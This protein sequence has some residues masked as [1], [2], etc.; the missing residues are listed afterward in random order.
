M[1]N[2]R[3]SEIK[4][5]SS[6][7][8]VATFTE[9]LDI[10]INTSNVEITTLIPNVPIPKVLKVKVVQQQLL[11]TTDPLTPYVPY[12][13]NF[14]SSDLTLFKSKNGTALLLTDGVTNKPTILGPEDPSDPTRNFLLTYL[15][16][17]VYNLESG[18]LVRDIINSQANNISQA[19]Y[20]IKQAQND[21][22]LSFTVTDEVK[23]RG[24]G[25]FDRLNQEGAYKIVRVGLHPTGSLMNG[26]LSFDDITNKIVNLL[27]VS[28]TSEKLI[29]GTGNSNFNGLTLNLSSGTV[30]KLKKLEIFYGDGTYFNYDI[31]QYGYQINNSKYDSDFASTLLTLNNHQIKLS[32]SV[33]NDDAFKI[34][35]AITTMTV[36]YEYIKLGRIVD[37]ESVEL[38]TTRQAVRELVPPL[39]N[40]FTLQHS[41]LIV[42]NLIDQIAS[43]SGVVFLDPN[44]NP[45][46]SAIHPAF[47]TEIPF[48]FDALPAHAG[49]Y[50]IDYDTGRVF[51]YGSN[52]ND[53][54]GNFP[55]TATYFYRFIFNPKLDYTY[56]SDTSE[57]VASPLRLQDLQNIPCKLV[58]NYEDTL[59]PD[60]DFIPQAHT[61]V[62]DERIGNKLNSSTCL[63]TQYSPITNVFRIY[64]ETSGELYKIQRWNSH[65]IYF[66]SNTPP[67]IKSALRERGSFINITNELLLVTDEF[68]NVLGTRILV[69]Y[70]KYNR[71]IASSEDAIGSS[72]NNSVSFSRSDLFATELYYD[73]Q[74]S[75]ADLNTNRL[76]PTQYQIDYQ[77]GI[78]YVGVSSSSAQSYE[79]GTINYKGPIIV[80]NN[81]HLISISN[82][83]Q[84]INNILGVNKH[85]DYSSFEDGEILPLTFN[86]TDERF[87][88]KDT[89]LP[90]IVSSQTIT[91]TDD[92]KDVRYIFDHYDLINNIVPTNFGDN[93]TI[94]ANVISLSE[95]GVIKQETLIIQ[96]G[97][98]LNTT[99]ISP[100]IELSSIV[101]L[102]R[103]EDQ[104]QLNGT[105]SGNSIILE[106]AESP[107]VGESVIVTYY[108][109]LN[110]SATPIVD[111]NR[112]DYFIDYTYL[113]DEILVSYEYG[114]NCIDFRSS[115]AINEGQT[116]YVTYK[117]GALRDALLKNFGS[118]VNLPILNNSFDI[119]FPRENYREALQAA[120]QSFTKGPTIPAMKSLVSQI[121]HIEPEL[122]ESAF[123]NWSLGISHLSP[124]PIELTGSP[125]LIA[126]KYDN[127]LLISNSDETVTFPVAS[128]LRLEEGTLE[129]WVIP[130]WDGLDNDA[131][132]T[133]SLTKDGY[134]LDVSQIYIGSDSHHPTYDISHQFCLNKIDDLSP[135]GVPSAIYTQ[136]GIF[137]FYDDTAKRWKVLAKDSVNGIASVYSGT[138]TSSGE[139][140]D[141]KFI[142]GLG[143]INDILRSSTKTI[144]FT[145]NLDTYDIESPDGYV[146]GYAE[147]GY[148]PADGY[149]AGYSFDG[150]DFMADDEHYLFDFGQT[151]VTNRFSIFKDGRGYLNFKVLDRGQGS[152]K[153]Q[154]QVSTDISN[155]KAG[156]K[157][158]VAVSWKLNTSDHR[159]E[160]HL[161][162]DGLEVPNIIK[163]GGRPIASSSDRFRTV[164]PEVV[165][166]S[167]LKI[168]ITYNDL[169]TTIDSNLVYSDTLNFEALGVV[170]GD[171]LSIKEIGFGDYTIIDISGSYLTLDSSMFSSLNQ[172]RF[173]I[174]EFSAIVSSEID[175]FSNI[176]VSI[177][178][179]AEETEIPGLRSEIPGYEISKNALNQNVLTLLGYAEAGDQI[180][181]R[182]LGLNHR[183][184]REK[185]FIWGNTQN[186]LKTQLPSPINL[187]EVKITA[188]LLPATVI[189]PNNSTIVD[190]AF[191]ATGLITSLP[192]NTME[193]RTLNIRINGNNV[194]FSMPVSVTITGTTASGDLSEVLNFSAP[195][196]INTSNK[197]KTISSVDVTVYPILDTKNS[198]SL[199]IKEAY[200]LTYS[201]GNNIFPVIRFSYKTQT[202]FH[203]QGNIGSD[204]IVDPLGYF[205]AS[206]I[207]QKLVITSP[208]SVI[209]TYT[210]IGRMNDTTI[211][212]S[213]AL[214]TTFTDGTYDIF[215]TTI[216]RS[217]FQNGFFTLE[218]AGFV[219]TPFTLN[220]SWYEFDYS[221]YLTI[222]WDPLTNISA[223]I[224]SDFTGNK[225]A[226]AVI[227]ELRILS[228]QLT[229]VR[230]GETLPSGQESITTDFISLKPLRPNSDT[231][232]LLHFDILPVINSA[233]FWVSATHD[234]LQA[235]DSVNANFGKSLIVM[236][237]PLVVDNKGYLSTTSEGTIEFWVSPRYD[238][239]N[240][241][242]FRF[243][244]DASSAIIEETVSLSS[245]NV[246][247]SSRA[248]QILSVRLQTDQNNLGTD[249]F[250][251]GVL[252]NDFQTLKLGTALPY[253]Q[254]PVKVQYLPS[255][256]SGNRLSIYKDR[257]GYVIFNIKLQ[258]TD[259]Q[260]RQSIFW[261]RDSWHRIRA[262]FKVNR[263]D[264]LDELR[265]FV[266]GEERGTILFGQGL[267]FGPDIIF[268]Q[269]FAGSNNSA[270]IQDINFKDPINQFYIG[271]DYL[272]ANLAQARIDNLKI[273][274]RVLQP[275]TVAGQPI[276][277]NF[278]SNLD[279]VFPV[280]QDA[281]TTYLLNFDTLI[282]TTDDLTVVRDEKFGIFNFTLNIIDS[283]GIVSN[284]AKVQQI[285]ET[286]ILAL[287]PAQSRVTLNYVK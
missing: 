157:H 14:K 135:I 240:D 9:E 190:G 79:L 128:N 26:S 65:S 206:I 36:D 16:D 131:T 102:I 100:G 226:K 253:Q 61:E 208:F 251:G 241:P 63:S 224:G 75:T 273:S 235:G 22:Y 90:Y 130:E 80:P 78:V 73:G 194:N 148:F 272:K 287:K 242:N 139:V 125:Q 179:N 223:Y 115:Q 6:T 10:F 146:D 91:V 196:S 147:D 211:Q 83:Y 202:G 274:N 199:E 141:V 152:R 161:F 59:V 89:S 214:E 53:G 86:L 262:T 245:G 20:D 117:V 219:N 265:L 145:F 271:S 170:A 218:Q 34:P 279:V 39:V 221:T 222:P 285:L 150:I 156:Q 256:L 81:P 24:E 1:P 250:A 60:L 263:T 99:F 106:A 252:E 169:N 140:Y 33:L 56:D 47:T 51:V 2:I 72:F 84:S 234:F 5:I 254:T 48:K 74:S 88:N 126:G 142:P 109:K 23:T 28:V 92:I 166:G 95:I 267:L 248:A 275:L 220:Q 133:F 7:S 43:N 64:N 159:D 204:I 11:I 264:H 189:G 118:L 266:D 50:S 15:K 200:S 187:D 143:E 114:D 134:T 246:K 19:L 227:D 233:N 178:H 37:P 4:V 247:L 195:T 207:G 68:T 155:W 69:I 40:Q 193:G 107:N 49:E 228:K 167:I 149:V 96:S 180:V 229:D 212:V 191:V 197:F 153:N 270:L 255:G 111:Y 181:I 122:I 57:L 182:T 276:D 13:V 192:S 249:Y 82:I 236:N 198:I 160:M 41:P 230:V 129:M 210:I 46:F 137:I 244:F 172:V 67:Q 55:P 282:K 168:P 12:S 238:T 239:Y 103:I 45:A 281:F 123:Q 31:E 76:L 259:Y 158:H 154:Y 25:P 52:T 17:N 119:S 87:V 116:Y 188:I 62:L 286:L 260:V 175:L 258:D 283:F 280:I 164:K 21:N 77:N 261:S 38:R 269:G 108:V 70:L 127:G 284:N 186:I 184:C 185:Q 232:M 58:Y 268:S 257:E 138:I 112:G 110:S 144:N 215:N 162:L 183:R 132:L 113:A 243:Y 71:I 171:T 201:E 85:I 105:I 27:T 42:S 3:L 121:T 225:Q 278:S 32:D 136:T 18:T 231:L 165:V 104:V 217:G 44:A 35:T 54:T 203:L 174:N 177:I 120:L 29:A 101:S 151:A 216:G 237:E 98:I 8:L 173:A 30:S 277:V 97:L 209:G 66:S 213:P 176:I 94:S 163:Y 93:V 124:N 205:P